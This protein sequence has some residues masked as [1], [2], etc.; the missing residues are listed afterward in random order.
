MEETIYDMKA[1]CFRKLLEIAFTIT[2]ANLHPVSSVKKV[3]S[4]DVV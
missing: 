4:K 3:S 1:K 2:A